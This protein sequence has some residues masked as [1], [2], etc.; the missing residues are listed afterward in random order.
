MLLGMYLYF[1]V[2]SS[3]LASFFDRISVSGDKDD[4][5]Q[6]QVG[7]PSRKRNLLSGT[8]QKDSRTRSSR[9]KLSDAPVSE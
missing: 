8:I 2:L 3:A 4:L 7:R 6:L 5:Q 9:S 1:F